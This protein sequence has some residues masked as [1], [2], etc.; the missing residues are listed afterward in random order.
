[1]IKELTELVSLTEQALP[2]PEESLVF[3]SRNNRDVLRLFHAIQSNNFRTEADA[4]QKSNVGERTKF[5]QVAK[6]L[7]HCLEQMVLQIGYEKETFDPLNN[8]RFRGFQLTAICKSLAVQSCK[9]ATRKVAEEL[10]RIGVEYA[11]PEFVVEACKSL[12]NSICVS[13]ESTQD[14]ESYLGMF[15]TYAQ[16]RLLEER[17]IT[18]IDLVTLSYTRKKA[19]QRQNACLAKSHLE[20]LKPYVGIIPSHNF[21]MAYY[22]LDSM[23]YQIEANYK[24][25]AHSND[26]AIQYFTSRQYPCAG[27]LRVFYY[28]GIINCLYLGQY[29]KGE[30]YLKIALDQVL[31]GNNH[32]FNTLEIGFYLK[33]HHEDFIGA[34]ELYSRAVRHKRFYVL[35]DSQRETWNILGAYL[36]IVQQLKGL[37]MP[38]GMAPKV[39]SSRFRNEIK[40]YSQDKTGMNIAILAAEV[41]L[42]FVEGKDNE[43]WDRIAALEKY[44]ERYLRNSD[45]THRSQLFIKILVIL[46]KYN[47]DSDKFLDKAQ[48]YLKELRTVPLQLT[49][50]AHELEIVPYEKLVRMIA[51]AMLKRKG[52]QPCV[53]FAR[54]LELAV[55]V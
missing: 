55:G 41:L 26:E 20:T 10:L 18:Y 19:L 34:A 45:D 25:S 32:W 33:M 5:R 3:F 49:N 53:K 36:Y 22:L 8:G 12:M 51:E 2:N 15:E 29:E 54:K 37:T 14:Y 17:A 35:R 39:K 40:D 48:P 46:S 4:I 28:H 16:W 47:Y 44:R 11:R 21:H 30:Q 13:G 27:T 31:V 7:L 9:N 6:E 52:K 24:A 43:L 38:E 23:Y 42:E 1:M 50:Q